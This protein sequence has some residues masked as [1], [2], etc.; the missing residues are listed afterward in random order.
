MK[1]VASFVESKAAATLSDCTSVDMYIN[2]VT[3]YLQMM[4]DTQVLETMSPE[5]KKTYLTTLQLQRKQLLLKMSASTA[6]PALANGN[7]DSDSEIE[8]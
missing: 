4:P 7:S 3:S 6:H 1:K 2:Q 8:N 5:S